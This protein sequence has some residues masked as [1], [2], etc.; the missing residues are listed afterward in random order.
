[1]TALATGATSS[2][3][4]GEHY[5]TYIAGDAIETVREQFD[6]EQPTKVLLRAVHAA[7]D[8]AIPQTLDIGAVVSDALTATP[9]FV[10]LA[11]ATSS[12]EEGLAV[13]SGAIIL[14]AAA[15]TTTTPLIATKTL[16]GSAAPIKGETDFVLVTGTTASAKLWLV[17]T[18]IAGW[19]LR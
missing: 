17:D 13:D 15:T 7:Q 5:L 14:G 10:G 6:L 18:S 12:E 16:S 8:S 3:V 1:V 2:L 9:L 19:S 4:A 11:P